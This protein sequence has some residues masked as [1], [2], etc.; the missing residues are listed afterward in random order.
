MMYHIRKVKTASVSTAIQIIK[1]EYHKRVVVKRMGSA[2]NKDEVIILWN[3]AEN[4]ITE[5]TKQIPLFTQEE[6]FISCEQDNS[7]RV[8]Q[9]RTLFSLSLSGSDSI[10]TRINHK[11]TANSNLCRNV[12]LSLLYYF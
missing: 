8:R 4:W 5:Q 6:R 2:H 11:K 1:H 10:K 7:E 12:W 3:N 9:M